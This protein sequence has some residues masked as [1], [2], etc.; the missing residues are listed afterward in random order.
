MENAP[1][2]VNPAE[3]AFPKKVCKTVPV[4]AGDSGKWVSGGVIRARSG[5]GAGFGR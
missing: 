5:P 3:R 1:F 4:F 2:G